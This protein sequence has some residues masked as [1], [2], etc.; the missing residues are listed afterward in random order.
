MNVPLHF[1]KVFSFVKRPLKVL[2]PVLFLAALGLLAGTKM[3]ALRQLPPPAQAAGVPVE[4]VPVTTGPITESLSYTGTIESAHRAAIASKVMAEIKTLTV[5]E[6]D[7]VAAGQLLVLLDDGELNERL[8]QAAAA[9]DQA[10]AALEQAEGA[11]SLSRTNYEKAS[12]NYIRGKQLLDAGAIP[13]SV[14]ENQYELPFLQAKESVERTAPAQVEAARA[15]L[16]QAEAGL[17]LAREAYGNA[18]IR[19]PFNGVVTAVH[20]YPGDL[21]AP[22]KPILALDDTGKMV[23]RVKVAEADLPHLRVG[24]KAT[25]RYPG[26]RETVSQVSRI[27]PAEDPLTRSTIV[28]VPVSS[29]GVRPGMSVD[30]SLEV[31]RSGRALLVPRRAVKTEQGKAWVFTVKNGRAVRVPV[32]PGLKNETH[33]EI[34]GDLKPGEPV[35]VSDLTRLYDGKEV[36]VYQEGSKS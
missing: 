23:A 21:A 14:F 3:A 31:G 20:Q 8:A 12:A 9:V 33:Y 30:V 18:T 26:G 35:V 16:A 17:A 2:L 28:E 7:R 19:A 15:Q 27:Y 36:F 10:R 4:T 5:K 32:T 11:L 1:L 34:K 6:G 22:G 13:R 24:Q 25:L 29:A